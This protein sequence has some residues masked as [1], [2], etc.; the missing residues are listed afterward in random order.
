[1]IDFTLDLLILHCAEAIT[2]ITAFSPDMISGTKEKSGSKAALRTPF[3][4]GLTIQV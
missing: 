4:S 3:N 1:M 2:Q